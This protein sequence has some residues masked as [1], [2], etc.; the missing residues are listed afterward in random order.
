MFPDLFAGASA[1]SKL[2]ALVVSINAAIML[3]A[4][5]ELPFVLRAFGPRKHESTRI[6]SGREAAHWLAQSTNAAGQSY[7]LFCI[8]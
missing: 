2:W 4:D 6:Y 5:I 8:A 3:R 7:N 1:A